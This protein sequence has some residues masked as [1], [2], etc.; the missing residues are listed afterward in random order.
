[1][2][3][4]AFALFF[5]IHTSPSQEIIPYQAEIAILTESSGA[6]LAARKRKALLRLSE[7]DDIQALKILHRFHFQ[8]VRKPETLK[9]LN[10]EE[11]RD[12]RYFSAQLLK[13]KKATE[14]IA[15]AE[16]K[17]SDINK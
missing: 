10:A 13:M 17:P 15:E 4:S 2:P 8:C 16:P 1:M 6:Q 7:T 11:L 3:Y 12:L 5:V 9:G 14:R